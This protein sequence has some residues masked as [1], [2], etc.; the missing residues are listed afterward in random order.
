[1]V[2]KYVSSRRTSTGS[3]HRLL[4]TPQDQEGRRSG[5]R[6]QPALID[7]PRTEQNQF[8]AGAGRE[9]STGTEARR[10]CSNRPGLNWTSG[11]PGALDCMHG[12]RSPAC[13]RAGCSLPIPQAGCA[14][15]GSWWP[16]AAAVSCTCCAS[17]RRGC[18]SLRSC[19]PETSGI[20]LALHARRTRLLGVARNDSPRIPGA[21]CGRIPPHLRRAQPGTAASKSRCR[22]WP[23]ACRSLDVHFFVSAVLLQKRT[24]GN[25]AEI[26]D[27]LAY[28]I[29]ERFKLRG[30]I[31]AVSAH[32]KMTATA[33]S[34]HS[35]R[36]GGADVLHQ[37]GLRQVLLHRRR[38][39]TSCW[40]RPSAC[41]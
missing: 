23:S 18:T 33:L 29:R 13:D 37:S 24:G 38:R 5:R 35:D 41:S 31:R 3:R 1:M 15:G 4:G 32:G 6:E 30:R 22:S 8:A 28:V 20:R 40:A 39:P 19:F 7:R 11:A 10:R 9:V 36:R 25:L 16:A 34:L 21:A 12:F 14:A 17:A 27:K 2:S 26:L